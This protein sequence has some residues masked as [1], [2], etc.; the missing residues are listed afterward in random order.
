MKLKA[1]HFTKT[2]SLLLL[3]SIL[4]TPAYS[5][6][7]KKTPP[8]IIDKILGHE[9]KNN[10]NEG[11]NQQIPQN[12]L[13]DF[14]QGFS[15]IAEKALPA[16]VNIATT[17]VIEP[18]NNSQ[19]SGRSSS[20]NPLEDFLREHLGGLP[21]QEI[22]RKIQSLGSGFVIKNTSDMM[23][24]VTNHHVIADAK[25]ISVFLYD[26][27][28]VRAELQASDERTDI[29]VIKVEKK[30]LPQ[31]HK[32][33][34]ALEW[35]ND[36][37]AKI[38]HWVLAIGN[39]FGLGSSVTNGIIS[40]KGRDLLTTGKGGKVSSYVDD[41]IQHSAQINM[42][43][44]GGCLLN[45]EGKVLGVNTAILSPSGGNVGVG[46][47]TPAGVA[48]KTVDQLIEFGRTQRGWLGVSIRHLSEEEIAT[49]GYKD[50]GDLVA[51]V[52]SG[53]PA[54]KGGMQIGDIIFEYDGKPINVQNRI[55]RL[56]GETTVGSTVDIKV[57][58]KNKGVVTLKVTVGEYE[59]ALKEG[60][61]NPAAP[62][63][64]GP[65]DSIQL[66]GMTIAPISDEILK[67]G[68]KG[69][70]VTDVDKSSVGAAEEAGVLPGDI[71]EQVNQND[72][73]S[74]QQFKETLEAAKKK[75]S[76]VF[77][78]GTREGRD[79]QYHSFYVLLKLKEEVEEKV[80]D[81]PSEKEKP[82]ATPLEEKKGHSEK[83]KK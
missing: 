77:L 46:F 10:N 61:L 29:A 74:V 40:S 55:T 50:Q 83:P 17:Q 58:R 44:S 70:L 20:G 3:S 24:I 5:R 8:T 11:A 80:K 12:S 13:V 2:V 82:A 48:R 71:I 52:A 68:K 6:E 45:T 30:H 42:G 78:S 57:H 63:A 47:A 60:K 4:Q 41:F 27:T 32:H 73:E 7:E 28:E 76:N 51:D 79:G 18:K 25:K 67:K 64:K 9:E 49:L 72:V 15:E 33:I 36:E 19:E 56:V 81:T 22:P 54:D 26:K 37:A 43:N 35:A 59:E 66:F 34:K 75:G 23:Y 53:G 39:P 14:S 38:G 62:K 16:V 1:T 65:K 21:G 69:V 31:K